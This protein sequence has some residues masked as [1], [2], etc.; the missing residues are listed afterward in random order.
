MLHF[1]TAEMGR[2]SPPKP[3]D[4]TKLYLNGEF[5]DSR[6][7]ETFSLK[8]PKDNTLVVEGI[9]I[10][11]SEDVDLAVSYAE[12][13]FKAYSKFTAMQKTTCFHNLAVLLE[14][15]LI[16]I[17]TLDSLTSGN[18]VSIIPTR[19]KDYIKNTIIYYSGWTDKQKGD[20]LPADDGK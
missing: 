3:E 7:R 10:A 19:E 1:Q 4:F 6:S 20:Y 12:E 13:A 16:D 17:L 18:P 5:V 14:E 9:P 11:N 2:I 8:N 15:H